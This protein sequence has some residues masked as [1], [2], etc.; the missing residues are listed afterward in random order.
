MTETPAP[1]RLMFCDQCGGKHVGEYS[2]QD[3]YDESK[4][5]YAVICPVD[6]PEWLTDYYNLFNAAD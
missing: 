6:N 3:T 2:H 4:P 1:T 5:I